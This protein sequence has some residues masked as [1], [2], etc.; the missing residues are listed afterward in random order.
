M[1]KDYI[2][3]LEERITDC[4][5]G[6]ILSLAGAAA[7]ELALEEYKELNG[8]VKVTPETDMDELSYLCGY[9]HFIVNNSSGLPIVITGSLGEDGELASMHDGKYSK[10]SISD[11][12]YY[13]PLELP[14]SPENEQQ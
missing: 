11:V 12:I 1:S 4:K 5:E 13:K 3:W 2:Q 14:P 9:F 7:F 10:Y 6:G 8:W